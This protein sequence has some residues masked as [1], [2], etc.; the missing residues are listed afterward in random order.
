MADKDP[1]F[2]IIQDLSSENGVPVHKALE[3]ETT[4][5]KNAVPSMI[6]KDPSGNFIYAA[7]NSSG[8]LIIDTDSSELANL[9][10]TAKVVGSGTEV[11]VAKITLQANGVYKGLGWVAG[12]FRDADFRIIGV[13]DVGVTDVETE[14]VAGILC[15]PGD[16]NDSEQLKNFE[17][18]AGG[19]GVQELQIVATN[20]N[21]LSDFRGTLTISEEQ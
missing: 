14:M 2:N 16:F 6:A 3:G 13:D 15:G 10:A 11:I 4:A 12:C 19:T 1:V 18:V 8:E 5:G 17:F 9:R 7:A 21:A 20:L